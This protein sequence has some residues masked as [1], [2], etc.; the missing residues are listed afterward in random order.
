MSGATPLTLVH[1]GVAPPLRGD[2]LP[3]LRRG[4]L[5]PLRRRER[6][7]VRVFTGPFSRSREEPAVGS[8]GDGNPS[9]S[10]RVRGNSLE[11]CEHRTVRRYIP[12]SSGRPS[13]RWQEALLNHYFLNSDGAI[14]F[15]H[16]CELAKK[17]AYQRSVTFGAIVSSAIEPDSLEPAKHLSIYVRLECRVQVISGHTES[18]TNVT[19]QPNGSES[20]ATFPRVD[21]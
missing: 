14:I 18:P 11:A 10:P 16:Q 4:A 19:I 7:R 21:V 9:L 12:E 2:A 6:V 8:I 17:P 15:N 20:I 5:S 13:H 1:R 3:L